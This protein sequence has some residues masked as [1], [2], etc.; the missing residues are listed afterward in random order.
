M[1]PTQLHGRLGL[2]VVDT[3]IFLL[4]LWAWILLLPILSETG[5]PK[6]KHPHPAA[7]TPFSA[8]AQSVQHGRCPGLVTQHLVLWV[9][10][11]SQNGHCGR[12][13]SLCSSDPEPHGPSHHTM[14]LKVM[15]TCGKPLD[16]PGELKGLPT[17]VHSSKY[18]RAI[19]L[20]SSSAS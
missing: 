10:A 13:A 3:Q 1:A 15:S 7:H 18:K 5:F 19:C 6:L 17:S 9:T 8:L 4:C 16:C 11:Q 12:R 14:S 20:R 2:G